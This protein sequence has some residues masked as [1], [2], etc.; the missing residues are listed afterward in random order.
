MR[1]SGHVAEQA[2]TLMS[3]AFKLSRAS[4][5]FLYQLFSSVY[6]RFPLHDEILPGFTSNSGRIPHQLIDDGLVC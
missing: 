4:H 6:R 1:A 3:H 5:H 2:T